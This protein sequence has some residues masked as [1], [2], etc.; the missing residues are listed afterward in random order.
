MKTTVPIGPTSLIGWLTGLAGLLPAF[1]NDVS[2]GSVAL[3]SSEKWTAIAG[4]VALGITQVG[5]YAQAH[6]QIKAAK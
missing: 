6:A 5:R 3:H 1:I 2:E 4:V